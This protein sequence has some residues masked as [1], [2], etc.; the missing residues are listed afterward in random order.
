MDEIMKAVADV[1]AVPE[2]KPRKVPSPKK[3]ITGGISIVD[4]KP[5]AKKKVQE[6]EE[7]SELFRVIGNPNKM[8]DEPVKPEKKKDKKKKKTKKKSKRKMKNKEAVDDEDEDEAFSSGSFSV[9]SYGSDNSF[10]SGGNESLVG[11]GSSHG[12]DD[13]DSDFDDDSESEFGNQKS[14]RTVEKRKEEIMQEKIEMLTR[15]SNMSRMGFTTTKKWSMKDDIDDIRFECY[16]MTRENNSRKSVKNMQHMLIT[17]ATIVEF[18]NS[19]VNPFNLKLQGF[20]KN[21]MLTVSD[22]DDSL[23]EIHHKWSGRTAVGPEMTVLFTFVTSAIFHHAG[24]VMN[25]PSEQ[26]QGNNTSKGP[27]M[28]SVL[29]LFSNMMPRPTTAQKKSNT[30]TSNP[31]STNNDQSPRK[32]RRPMK[33]PSGGPS[34]NNILPSMHVPS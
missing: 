30:S 6:K 23:E 8:S 1:E 22:Y 4:K 32:H 26:K 17:A 27:D 13:K 7:N 20:S 14:R 5:K 28:S 33:G 19:F 2:I 12:S 24:N 15:I 16:R 10:M 9:S 21:L 18:A 25:A 3:P 29:G 31:I 34:L 11:G